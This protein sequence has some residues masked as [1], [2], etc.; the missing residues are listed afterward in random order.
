V[1]ASRDE[2]KS[3][4][5]RL[6]AVINASNFEID[7]WMQ[8]AFEEINT[9]CAQDFLFEPQSVKAIVAN[10][11][12][13]AL[14]KILSGTVT[15][16]LSPKDGG[17]SIAS[18]DLEIFEGEYYLRYRP[19]NVVN[20][21]PRQQVHKT[22]LLKGDWGYAV[23]QQDLLVSL[24]N[25]L[26]TKYEAHRLST[27]A[28]VIADGTNVVTS[29][30]ATD[31]AT[32]I[33]LLN[34][35]QIVENSHFGDTAVHQVADTRTIS[36]VSATDTATAMT[37]ANELK[38]DYNAHIGDTTVHLAADV[39]NIVYLSVDSPIFP[40][41]VKKVFVRL[42]QRLAVRAHEE[43]FIQANNYYVSEKTGDDYTYDLSDGTMRNLLRPEDFRLLFPY[44][45]HGLI[46]V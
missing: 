8:E 26:K 29:P 34:E 37:L 35:L 43:D 9:F 46:A 16:M 44:I 20:W 19:L 42:V 11:D 14:P 39:V 33:T 28:H 1:Y 30:D 21:N 10:D 25:E 32:A 18:D 4:S 3:L 2:I 17:D 7:T 15:G 23:S 40:A 31:L 38:V 6:T 22:L 36:S 41:A 5:Q 13:L 27:T 12:F 24:A 45:N